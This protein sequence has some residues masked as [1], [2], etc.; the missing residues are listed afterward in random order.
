[1]GGVLKRMGLSGIIQRIGGYATV[2]S[3]YI[4]KGLEMVGTALGQPDTA[5][6]GVASGYG[7]DYLGS[8]LS[9]H[10]PSVSN[11]NN[12]EAIN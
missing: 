12:Q 8:K 2:A 11:S 10:G 5:A 9:Q 1:M 4:S 6:L 3:P 7:L